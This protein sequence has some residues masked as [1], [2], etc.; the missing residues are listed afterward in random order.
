MTTIAKV[1]IESKLLEGTQT[2]QYTTDGVKS[3]IDKF[4]VTNQAATSKVLNVNLVPSGG[5]AGSSN[6]IIKNKTI[7]PGQTYECPELVGQ[8]LEAGGF[9]STLA[10][11]G[12]SLTCRANGIIIA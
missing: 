2:T 11:D 9:I 6:L 10:T 3:R 5:S 8:L 12:T 7:L 4:T 1:F